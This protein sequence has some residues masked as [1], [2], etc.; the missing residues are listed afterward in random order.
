MSAVANLVPAITFIVG[1]F[2]GLE[3]LEF[4]TAVGKAKVFGTIMGICGAMLFTFYK[5]F[6]I[7]PLKSD[8]N[9]LPGTSTGHVALLASDHRVLGACLALASCFSYAIW[10]ILQGALLIV[11]GLYAVLWG[12]H[13]EM[14]KMI[15]EVVPSNENEAQKSVE[16]IV[17]SGSNRS[18][19]IEMKMTENGTINERKDGISCVDREERTLAD[20]R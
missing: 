2:V 5:G 15:N 1:I 18:S 17:V 11:C 3:R 6:P 9:L 13:N 12:K 10:I 20:P 16:I 7:Q 14:K 19:S 8:I 4:G